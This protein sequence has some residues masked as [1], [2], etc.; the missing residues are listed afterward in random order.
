MNPRRIGLIALVAYIASIPLANYAIQHWGTAPAFPGGP[1]T[2]P[3]GF[4][5]QAPSGVLFI[6]LALVSRDAVQRALGRHVAVKAILIGAILSYFIAPNLAWASAIAFLLGELADFVV[7]TPLAE[8]HIYWA[9]ALSG[10]V[11]A[12][13][14]SLIFLQLAFGSTQFWQ[15]NV[16][17][18]T[19][20]SLLAL[21][22]IFGA[23][24]VV[25]RDRLNRAGA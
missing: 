15:G 16:L 23:R 7:Y 11:G 20:M 10:V 22:F 25:P 14:D 2:I 5:Y 17:G 8:R 6:G 21:P 9:V 3:V 24:R 13:I 19:W 18:K 4:G 12:V 1:H